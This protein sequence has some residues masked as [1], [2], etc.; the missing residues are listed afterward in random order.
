MKNWFKKL[1]L[2]LGIVL[3]GSIIIAQPTNIPTPGT[4]SVTYDPSTKQVHQQGLI[5][6]GV[7]GLT[8]VIFNSLD[9]SLT[10]AVTNVLVDLQP[11]TNAAQLSFKLLATN[12]VYFLQPT[13]LVAGLSFVINMLQDTIGTRTVYFNTNY[14][15]FP[16]G[17]ILTT[18]TNANAWSIFSCIVGRSG[19]NVAV[20]QTLNF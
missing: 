5:F 9:I 2:G 20:V 18:T 17:Q 16:S 12:N 6:L 3:I 11:Y 19:T 15:K 10:I 14:W 7:S 1:I 4:A 8:N 13:N